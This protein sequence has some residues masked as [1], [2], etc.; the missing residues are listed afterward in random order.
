MAKV[1]IKLFFG[2][3]VHFSQK[4]EVVTIEEKMKLLVLLALLGI[5]V[6]SFQPND[7]EEVPIFE[8]DEWKELHPSY[9]GF[10]DLPTERNG[11]VWNGQRV[12]DGAIPYQVKVAVLLSRT[13]WCGGS[14]VSNNF[15]LSG[16]Q[17][18]PVARDP[19]VEVSGGRS[20]RTNPTFT[21]RVS[22]ITMHPAYNVS[23]MQ[24][25]SSTRVH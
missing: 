20:D 4:V 18:F 22:Q 2:R 19:P 15:V 3:A 11:R 14:I 7:L 10:T 21:I 6:N 25:R 5:G 9:S 16:A 12:N 13:T 1:F 8:T 24:F 17:C 23:L